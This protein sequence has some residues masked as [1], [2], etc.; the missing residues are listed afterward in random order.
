MVMK[1]AENEFA[2]VGMQATRNVL[3]VQKVEKP[4]SGKP[5]NFIFHVVFFLRGEFCVGLK[6]LKIFGGVDVQAMTK[7]CCQS[8]RVFWTRR[9]KKWLF[10]VRIV[11]PST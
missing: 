3:Q 4:N 11:S 6:S 9:V 8:L 5:S 1:Y 7:L 10:G 2:F